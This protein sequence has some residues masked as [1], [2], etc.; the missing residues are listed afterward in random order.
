MSPRAPGAPSDQEV[1][2]MRL[3]AKEGAVSSSKRYIWHSHLQD[4]KS[5]NDFPLVPTR[6]DGYDDVANIKAQFAQGMAGYNWNVPFTTDDAAYMMRKRDD[7]ERALFDVWVDNK[8]DL[9]DPAQVRMLQEIAPE[10]YRRKE[11]MIDTMQNIASRY[12]KLRLRGPRT[13]DDLFLEWQVETGRVELP[14]GPVWNPMLWRALQ[15]NNLEQS[16]VADR[17][18]NNTRYQAGMFSPLRWITENTQ[19]WAPSVVNRA[20]IYGNPDLHQTTLQTPKD[21][22]GNWWSGYPVMYPATSGNLMP[23]DNMRDDDNAGQDERNRA[24]NNIALAGANAGRTN[25][26]GYRMNP[27]IERLRIF[28]EAAA[29]GEVPGRLED[30]GA[31]GAPAVVGPYGAPADVGV[32]AM[33]PGAPLV[34]PA[35]GAYGRARF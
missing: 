19:G 3:A 32:A 14:M 12:A 7:Q 6:S 17:D 25:D 5:T 23:Y 1:N 31:V 2:V 13:L 30:Y 27:A 22:Y 33:A 28:R 24:Y 29:R 35:P 26:I 8:F 21:R 18:W 9:T 15:S 34:R 10:L 20:D 16:H 4:P 11:E